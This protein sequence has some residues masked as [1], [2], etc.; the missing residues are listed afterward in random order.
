MIKGGRKSSNGIQSKPLG[1]QSRQAGA[2][3]GMFEH[4][5]ENHLAAGEPAWNLSNHPQGPESWSVSRKCEVLPGPL[6]KTAQLLLPVTP[7]AEQVV[8]S[9]R[10]GRELSSPHMGFALEF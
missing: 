9:A 6:T 7:H 2:S 5:G 1:Y 8:V 3:F 4:S 10:P